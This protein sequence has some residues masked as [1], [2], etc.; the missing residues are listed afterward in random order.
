MKGQES[1]PLHTSDVL[2]GEFE[3]IFGPDKVGELRAAIAGVE[4][5]NARL[6]HIHV[7]A[8]KLA[9]AALCLS[10]GG[11]RSA[12]FG[13]GVLQALA[14]TGLLTRFHYVSTVSGGGYIGSWL[15]AWLRW[16]GSCKPVIEGLGA[17]GQG[18]GP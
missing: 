5:E 9:P 11:I 1:E 10:G 4:D 15:S 3:A 8:A 13:L 14:D 16:A 17:L 7:R 6:Q 2:L 18:A 12:S